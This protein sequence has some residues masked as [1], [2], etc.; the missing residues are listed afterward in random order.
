MASFSDIVKFQRSQ[1]AG[2]GS[3]LT[4]AIGQSTLQKMDPR[5]YLFSSRGVSTALFPFL[6]GYQAKTSATTPKLQQAI[7]PTFD[8]Q[9]SRRIAQIDINTRI[10]AKNSMVLPMMARDMNLVRQNIS[11]LVRINSRGREVG[12]TKA[13]MF[14]KR[15]GQRESAYESKF[16]KEGSLDNGPGIL[17]T[18]AG[19]LGSV[20]RSVFSGVT[21]MAGSIFGLVGGLVGN[22][23][24]FALPLLL[25]GG[26]IIS[27][28]ASKLSFKGFGDTFSKLFDDI[29][30]GIKGLFRMDKEKPFFEQISDAIKDMLGVSRERNLAGVIAEK[31]DEIFKTD[32]FTK[33]LLS[34]VTTFDRFLIESRVFFDTAM[35]VIKQSYEDIKEITA[36]ALLGMAGAYLGF[37]FG[38]NLIMGPG[39]R[40]V[41]GAASAAGAAGLPAAAAAGAPAEEVARQEARKRLG[42]LLTQRTTSGATVEAVGGKILSSIGKRVAWAGAATV[43]PWVGAII[44]AITLGEVGYELY[45]LFT[46]PSRVEARAALEEAVKA[47]MISSD[48]KEYFLNYIDTVEKLDK[49]EDKI[50]FKSKAPTGRSGAP[51]ESDE[52]RKVR[53]S[54]LQDLKKERDD[55]L[56]KIEEMKSKVSPSVLNAPEGQKLTEAKI[57]KI[58]S[59]ADKEIEQ[60]NQKRWQELFGGGTSPQKVGAAPIASF[61]AETALRNDINA[62]IASSESRSYDSR[63]G[64]AENATINGKKI[65]DSTV[66]E[67][68]AWQKKEIANKTNKQ[69]IGRYAFMNVEERAN[70]MGLTQQQ[71]ESMKFDAGM[72]ER[73]QAMLLSE[74]ISGLKKYNIPINDTTVALAHGLGAR[75]AAEFLQAIE[76]GEGGMWAM[77]M[78]S[79]VLGRPLTPQEMETNKNWLGYDPKTGEKKSVFDI[80]MQKAQQVGDAETINKLKQLSISGK[81]PAETT[82][83]KTSSGSLTAFAEES[84]HSVLLTMA[85]MFAEMTQEMGGNIGELGQVLS[86][87]VKESSAKPAYAIGGGASVMDRDRPMGADGY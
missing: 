39:G 49:L 2:V 44:G 9:T 48:D 19:G 18:V 6:K 55:V 8:R 26:Y 70:K 61:L 86:A 78:L 77:D 68:I 59:D 28:L 34:L 20:F 62:L 50:K 1:G 29:S 13:D 57:A 42:V 27:Q 12:S 80:V 71:K 23:G 46:G 33:T 79:K 31:L 47:G 87:A 84:F 17:S 14:F 81:T 66:D 76:K 73:M 24:W 5:N 7:S 35:V 10:N 64:F 69:G 4:T 30:K 21:G 36:K 75:G 38:K 63:F 3:S 53:L 51:S 65:T 22:L 11:K 16:K 56:N 37:Q 52:A 15:A 83:P 67:I 72:Q 41:P 85:G 82:K 25:A 74:N 45:Q 43:S 32:F 58:R 40:G 60:L 54:E